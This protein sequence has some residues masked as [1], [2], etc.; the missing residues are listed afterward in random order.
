MLVPQKRLS[1]IKDVCPC[2]TK[3]ILSVRPEYFC[4]ACITPDCILI[5]SCMEQDKLKKLYETVALVNSETGL[6][7]VLDR[8]LTSAADMVNAEASAILLI[9]GS[10]KNLKFVSATGPAATEVKKYTLPVGKGIAGWVAQAG[11]TLVVP[12]TSKDPRFYKKIADDLE[13]QHESMAAVPLKVKGRTVGVMEVIHSSAEVQFGREDTEILEAFAH[14]AALAIEKA[15]L[16]ERLK[17]QNRNLKSALSAK[18]SFSDILTKDPMM[19]Q[20]IET[21][22]MVA[23]TNS[24]VLITGESGTGK[25]LLAQA[26]H[27]E[28]PRADGPFLAINCGAIPENLLEAEL[29]GYEKGA[30]TGANFRKLGK[31]ELADGGTLFLDEVGELPMALQVKLLRVLQERVIERLGGTEPIE[32]DVRVIAATNKRLEDEIR[33]KRF[34]EDLFYRLNVVPLHIPPLRTRRGDIPPLAEH[35]LKKF[36]KTMQ[37]K[38]AGFSERAVKLLTDY[39]WPGNIRELENAVERAV[40]LCTTDKI[41]YKHLSL[42]QMKEL[43]DD[44]IV[45]FKDAQHRF[46]RDYIIKTLAQTAGNQTTAAKLLDIQRTYLSRLMKELNIPNG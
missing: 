40:V 14:Q 21:G 16:Y 23:K 2:L 31:V 4:E 26:I 19:D 12:D 10:G 8:V 45:C 37:K 6:T 35:F 34:R 22:R 36:T 3:Y 32:A 5:C 42:T 13:E 39:P 33:E 24:T 41:E 1:R 25:E 7:E 20:I 30:F 17:E 9:D 28:S 46:K 18:F 27:N 15:K 29:F 11:E 43:S 38:I 44:R